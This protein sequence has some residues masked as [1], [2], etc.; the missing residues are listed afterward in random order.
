MINVD[1]KTIPQHLQRYDTVGDWYVDEGILY[2]RVSDMGDKDFENLVAIHEY[3]EAIL[4]IQRGIKEKDVTEFDI[5]Y[6]QQRALG[7]IDCQSEPGD[8]EKAPYRKE[9]FFATSVERLISAELNVNW[10][11]YDY[12]IQNLGA[13]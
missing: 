11:Q 1:I 2:I 6:E 7:N 5:W 4:C 8:H 3:V 13:M 12:V 9:H 10:Q